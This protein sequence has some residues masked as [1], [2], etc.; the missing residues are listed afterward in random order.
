MP[1]ALTVI[2]MAPRGTLLHAPDVYM[3]KLAIGPGYQGRGHAL[4]MSP[5]ERVS[6]LAAAK[7]AAQGP[8]TSP[9]ACWNV[10]G[11]RT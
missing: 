2:A 6:A 5:S 4:A 7:G 9:S 3:D 11:M 1:N 10:P 8:R